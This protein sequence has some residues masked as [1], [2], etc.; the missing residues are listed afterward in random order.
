MWPV[1]FTSYAAYDAA[2]Y[3]VSGFHELTHKRRN[4]VCFGIEREMP[5]IEKVYFRL[6]HVVAIALRLPG[7]EREIVLAPNHQHW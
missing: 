1:N 4:L 7:T 5:R 3:L 2:T 6:R